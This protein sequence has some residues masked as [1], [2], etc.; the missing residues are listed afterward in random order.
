[1]GAVRENR[2]QMAADA[3]NAREADRTAAD[4]AGI[5]PEQSSAMMVF[6]AWYVG[7]PKAAFPIRNP[8]A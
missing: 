5:T 2:T 4:C 7:R 1:M 6:S 8:R 3:R